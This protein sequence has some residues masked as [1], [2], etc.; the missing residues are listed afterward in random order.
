[1]KI[2]GT[3]AAYVFRVP[4]LYPISLTPRFSEVYGGASYHNRFSGLFAHCK[5]AKAVGDP[6]GAANTQ[7][8]Q[9]VNERVSRH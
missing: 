9:G 8:K 4:V 1:V 2:W 6:S 7:L 5:T 3:Q